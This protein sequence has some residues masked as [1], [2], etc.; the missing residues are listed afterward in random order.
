MSIWVFGTSNM[1]GACNGRHLNENLNWTVSDGAYLKP[2]DTMAGQL[3]EMLDEPVLNFAKPGIDNKEIIWFCKQAVQ[4]I[5]SGEAKKP[6]HVIVEMRGWPDLG[7]MPLTRGHL[8]DENDYEQIQA[9]L[10]KKQKNFIVTR[11]PYYYRDYYDENGYPFNKHPDFLGTMIGCGGLGVTN[12]YGVFTW[13]FTIAINNIAVRKMDPSQAARKLVSNPEIK[14]ESIA[15]GQEQ[16]HFVK[17]LMNTKPGWARNYINWEL[18]DF[19]ETLNFITQYAS[20]IFD[21]GTNIIRAETWHNEVNVIRNLFELLDIPVTIMGWDMKYIKDSFRKIYH[22]VD[23]IQAINLTDNIGV[24]D[25]LKTKHSKEYADDLKHCNC[26]HPG[27][28]THHKLAE[29]IVDKIGHL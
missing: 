24:Q 5:K 7:T 12:K 6:R 22:E 15:E 21:G 11:A 27:P 25:Y 4:Q 19:E 26:G 18:F 1:A 14:I 29:L 23:D 9:V 8:I 16:E 3:K 2:E 10:N 17:Y 20:N 13:P 28:W